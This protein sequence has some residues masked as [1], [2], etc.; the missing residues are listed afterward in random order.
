MRN[1][2]IRDQVSLWVTGVSPRRCWQGKIAKAPTGSGSAS[3]RY[4]LGSL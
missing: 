1:A 2:S 3:N 4:G